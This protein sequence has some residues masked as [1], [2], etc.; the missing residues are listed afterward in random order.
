MTILFG[1]FIIA[2]GLLIL[3]FCGALINR[4]PDM[5]RKKPAEVPTE[6]DEAM[7]RLKRRHT[8]SPS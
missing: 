6:F 4:L 2:S 1:A 8:G 7:E 5:A 3:L